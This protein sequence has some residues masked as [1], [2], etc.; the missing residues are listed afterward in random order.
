MS[1]DDFLDGGFLQGEDDDEVV[2]YRHLVSTL[3]N[4]FTGFHC[5]IG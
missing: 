3:L 2:E 5:R 1:V 4:V